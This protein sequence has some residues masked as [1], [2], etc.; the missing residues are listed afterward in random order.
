MPT[1]RTSKAPRDLKRVLTETAREMLEAGGV[2]AL[3][4]RAVARK[5]EVSAGAPYKHFMDRHELLEAIADDGFNAL[6]TAMREAYDSTPAGH[7]RVV[8]IGAAYALFAL[9]RPALYKVM[10]EA[11][12]GRERLPPEGDGQTEATHLMW[13]SIREASAPGVSE[14]DVQLAGIAAWSALHGMIDLYS[15]RTVEAVRDRLGGQQPFVRA[16]LDHLGVFA[17][18]PGR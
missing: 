13:Q 5:A 2:E 9:R 6:A 8:A 7:G 4:M 1:A 3:S 15:F 17:G 12:R 16:V 11:T 14:D 18:L 10:I